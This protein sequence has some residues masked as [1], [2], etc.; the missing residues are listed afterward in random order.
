[1]IKIDTTN[2]ISIN[3]QPTGL[4]VV[5]RAA[6]TVVYTPESRASG[7][8]YKEHPMPHTRYSL[9]H[10]TPASGAAGRS[11]FE[12]DILALLERL[13]GRH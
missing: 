2:R 13:N 8:E 3:G 12:A 6:G 4:A 7:I 11:Q 5:Q 1:M 10:D 9:A